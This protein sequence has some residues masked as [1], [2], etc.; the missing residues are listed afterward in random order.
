MLDHYRYLDAT[1][2]IERPGSFGLRQYIVVLAGRDTQDIFALQFKEAAASVLTQFLPLSRYRCEAERIIQ[3]QRLVQAKVDPFLGRVQ[4]TNGPTFHV[5]QLFEPQAIPDF[6]KQS[7]WFLE[8]Y[9]SSCAD[10]LAR[11]HARSGDPVQIAAYLG[12]GGGF[13]E[14]VAHFSIKC[15]NQVELDHQQLVGAVRTG[16]IQASLER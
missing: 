7:S 10:L 1:R 8:V 3:G 11:A 9:A 12:K 13:E 4:Q 15:A 2:L 14:A 6:S 16:Q 5:R